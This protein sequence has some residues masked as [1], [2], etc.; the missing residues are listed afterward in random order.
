MSQKMDWDSSHDIADQTGALFARTMGMLWRLMQSE[1]KIFL[2]AVFATV[3]MQTIVLASP[4]SFKFL[5][6]YI[7]ENPEIT[8]S[9]T[10][11]II[12]GVVVMTRFAQLAFRWYI[13]EPL[14]IKPIIKLENRW[15]LFAQGKLL[16]LAAS[17]HARENTGKKAAKVAK[18]IDKLVG[19]L[20]DSF[21]NM[22][23]ALLYIAVNL[24]ILFVLDWR[25]A[26]VML[27][28][29]PIAALINLK[30]YKTLY[31][32]WDQWERL[33]EKS[34]GVF[35]QSLINLP[36]VQSYAKEETEQS[37]L[38]V[39]RKEMEDVDTKG[40]ML[41]RHFHFF[42]GVVLESSFGACVVLGV[43]L[44][45]I[46][47]VSVGTLVYIFMTGNATNNLLRNMIH[48]YMRILKDSV[49]AER[50]YHLSVEDEVIPSG[51]KICSTDRNGAF[52]LSRVCFGYD[53]GSSVLKDIS[54]S[55][56]PGSMVAFIGRSG[57]GKSTLISLLSR[58]YDV[59][60]GAI[61]YKEVNI[62]DFNLSEYR[63]LFAQVHQ[64]IDIF[65]GTIRDN[66]AYAYPEASD[67]LVREALAVAHLKDVYESNDR[68]AEGIFTEVGER[69]I[70]LSGGQRQRVGIA[71][72]YVAL[73]SGAQ[74]LI[75]DEATSSLDSEAE[76]HIHQFITNMKREHEITIIAI[77][78]RLST[79]RESD[80][81]F[82]MDN[83]I[84]IDSGTHTELLE[85]SNLYKHMVDLQEL[86]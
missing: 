9:S 4:L 70:K 10:L 62:K 56:R 79:V 47:S 13:I 48:S 61:K 30:A 66:V 85:S 59:T 3:V 65:E 36:T 43:F 27:V 18:A 7:Q 5:L 35:V 20:V 25:I 38:S 63:R 32:I 51:N 28:A 22:L 44:L 84:I 24:I 76:S 55:I 45:S 41:M 77:A 2:W 52:D 54:M 80:E 12:V 71:R 14:V 83:G 78:H 37:R 60:S 57:S 49:A 42:V 53:Q 75:L 81:I 86:S 8:I 17:Y 68:F 74:V 46:E 11:L 31:P 16:S 64:D 19:I 33:K 73:K 34:N 82:L 40:I 39:I 69:G 50:L 6:D 58:V 67:A 26:V 1:K 29:L 23:P 72:A 21:L 15:P